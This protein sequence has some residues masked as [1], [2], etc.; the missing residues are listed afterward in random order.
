MKHG[1]FVFSELEMPS[2]VLTQNKRRNYIYC[3]FYLYAVREM[4]VR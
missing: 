2:S 4:A 1:V 3:I